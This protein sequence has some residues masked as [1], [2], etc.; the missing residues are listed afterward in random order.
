MADELT[1]KYLHVYFSSL[2]G[3]TLANLTS[4]P[5]DKNDAENIMRCTAS[6]YTLRHVATVYIHAATVYTRSNSAYICTE[7]HYYN[8]KNGHV[9]QHLL[10]M[11]V[12]AGM[13][14]RQSTKSCTCTST[15]PAMQSL[16][17]AMPCSRHRRRL[18]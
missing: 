17:L 11:H 5:N 9:G 3:A 8:N 1:T 6:M 15:S 7:V 4:S 10:V 2:R 14:Y 12:R 13:H 18:R 16:S